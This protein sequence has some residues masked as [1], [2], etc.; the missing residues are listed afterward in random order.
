[1]ARA[2]ADTDSLLYELQYLRKVFVNS[3]Y[4][5][6]HTDWT[7]SPGGAG[8]QSPDSEDIRGRVFIPF[9]VPLHWKKAGQKFYLLTSLSF[10][11]YVNSNNCKTWPRALGSWDPQG[12]MLMWKSLHWLDRENNFGKV[13]S[14]CKVYPITTAWQVRLGWPLLKLNNIKLYL[15]LLKYYETSQIWGKD[16]Y[17]NQ[18]KFTWTL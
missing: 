8:T 11:P 1:M 17:L 6:R 5:S 12:S 15:I 18:L 10:V 3:G 4:S 16:W 9:L 13:F 2:I 14:T 7:L